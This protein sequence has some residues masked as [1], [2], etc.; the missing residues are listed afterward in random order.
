MKR[1][2]VLLIALVLCASSACADYWRVFDNAGL[3]SGEEIVEIEQAISDFQ[4]KTNMDFA[5]LTTDDYLGKKDSALDFANWFYDSQNFGFGH[6]A[7]GML[8]YI[9]MNQRISYISTCGEM[10]DIFDTITVD[11]AHEECHQF[12]VDGKYSEAVMK[13]IELATETVET[14]KKDAT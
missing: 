8:Y 6:R 10:V 14:Y 11:H 12:L 9:D 1:I 3:F 2:F 5:A 4:R 7:N 13:M